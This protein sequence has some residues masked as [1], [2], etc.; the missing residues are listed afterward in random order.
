M[1]RGEGSLGREEMMRCK[2]LARLVASDGLA[3]ATWS[4]RVAVG[5]HLLMCRHCRL[6]TAQMRDLGSA[7]RSL[8]K[9]EDWG[10]GLDRMKSSIL[11]KISEAETSSH[12]PEI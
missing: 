7:A 3:E 6:Y 12:E 10:P 2:E 8:F 5:F 9:R 4:R 11:E 1:P